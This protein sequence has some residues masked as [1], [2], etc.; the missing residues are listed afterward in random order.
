MLTMTQDL[1]SKFHELVSDRCDLFFPAVKTVYFESHLRERLFLCG[2][3]DYES[4]Y[5]YLIDQP[6]EMQRLLQGLTVN[7]THFFRNPAQFRMLGEEVF[8]ELI[9]KK[10]REVVKSW[11]DEARPWKWGQRHPSM[12]LRVWSAGCSTG[13]E[14]YSLAFTV[15]ESLKFPRAWDI[16]I[17][18]T[19]INRAVLD[20]ARRGIYDDDSA[21]KIKPDMLARYTDRLDGGFIVKEFPASLVKF[22][23]ANLKDISTRPGMIR[24][25]PANGPAI[26]LDASGYFDVIFCRNVMIYFDR[27]AQ[28]RLVNSLYNCLTPGGFL[29]TGDSEPLHLFEHRFET[30][31]K[32][33]AIYYVKPS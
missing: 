18:A 4:Y 26:D 1:F 11:G 23:E 25:K 14:A 10:N 28:Q 6:E 16:E 20:T 31:V 19:D 13:E 5:D 24:L 33:D 29:F 22:Y 2:H 32:G 12:H 9:E 3:A 17:T 21:K 8:P 7:E 30:V 15:L 27:A